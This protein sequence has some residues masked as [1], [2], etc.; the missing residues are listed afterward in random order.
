M[1]DH[2]AVDTQVT[3]LMPDAVQEEVRHDPV[4]FGG[5]GPGIDCC[6]KE[7]LIDIFLRMFKHAG[8]NPGPTAYL[9][10]FCDAEGI[11]RQQRV[12]ECIE[13]VEIPTP[14][15]Q[16]IMLAYA[17]FCNGLVVAGFLFMS[18]KVRE[19]V[20]SKLA[21]RS[22]KADLIV[23]RTDGV[24]VTVGLTMDSKAA[25]YFESRKRLRAPEWPDVMLRL[26]AASRYDR[27]TGMAWY[28]QDD[29]APILAWTPPEC[30]ARGED[31]KYQTPI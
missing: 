29:I 2:G 10:A 13:V 17:G 7:P 5:R 22:S 1:Y 24:C 30:G 31:G 4:R 20:W 26:H 16:R 19:V 11:V 21:D 14:W 9:N 28:H 6:T 23:V 8:R 27:R 3:F 18:G 15:R 12:N 25:N